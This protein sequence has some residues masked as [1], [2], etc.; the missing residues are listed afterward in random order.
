[1]TPTFIRRQ[2][3]QNGFIMNIFSKQSVVI[4]VTV[5]IVG[6]LV[7]PPTAQALSIGS[8]FR[9]IQKAVNGATN[10]IGSGVQQGINQGTALA[11]DMASKAVD[12]GRGLVGSSMRTAIDLADDIKNAGLDAQVLTLGNAQLALDAAQKTL[13]DA[14]AAY[15]TSLAATTGYAKLADAYAKGYTSYAMLEANQTLATGVG[16][17]NLAAA[18]AEAKAKGFASYA[19]RLAKDSAAFAAGE[20]P[21]LKRAMVNTYG[22][23][24]SLGEQAYSKALP[25]LMQAYGT[26]AD[27]ANYLTTQCKAA[28]TSN[29]GK[30]TPFARKINQFTAEQ[31]K[32]V[33]RIVRSL[34]RGDAP[35]TQ[36]ASDVRLVGSALGLVTANGFALVGN[37]AQSNFTLSVTFSG[38]WIVG[39]NESV[40]YSMDTFPP[41]NMALT[42]SAGPQVVVGT[43]DVAPGADVEI[44]L[45]WGA[46]SSWGSQGLT[47]GISGSVEAF[48]VGTSWAIPEDLMMDIFRNTKD[49]FSGHPSALTGFAKNAIDSICQIPSLSV[50]VG[51]GVGGSA[52]PNVGL[53]PGWTQVLWKGTPPSASSS[54]VTAGPPSSTP[55]SPNPRLDVLDPDYYVA[56]NS[57]LKKA[58]FTRAQAKTH[59]LASGIN[60]G[61]Q[62]SAGFSAQAYLNRYSDLKAGCGSNWGCAVDHWTNYGYAEKRD[63]RP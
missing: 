62:P 2:Y 51:I 43:G 13:T 52:G 58:G 61:R 55:T 53:S 14:T 20:L 26:G 41:Y 25:I 32:A 8:I 57:D 37:A 27:L 6:T 47:Q 34:A 12:A 17:A 36:T 21:A 29:A 38:G 5:A 45:S 42:L 30:I 28:F 15:E 10:A 54:P 11:E 16:Y 22:Q 31:K 48:S 23:A 1:M 24:R 46:G 56:T 19:E 40:G 50:A 33:Y 44:G 63:P 9:K 4:L 49:F 39:A 7:A 18:D 3:E 59:W 60:E 35:D